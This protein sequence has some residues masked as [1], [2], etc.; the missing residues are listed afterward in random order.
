MVAFVSH[1]WYRTGIPANARSGRVQRAAAF[2]LVA[3]LP[4]LFTAQLVRSAVFRSDSRSPEARVLGSP[5]LAGIHPG[6]ETWKRQ[7]LGDFD[8]L[9]AHLA[10]MEP[11]DAPLFVM[12]NEPMLYFVSARPPLFADHAMVLFLAGWDMLPENDRATPP[13]S[14]LIGRLA[15]S[16]DAILVHRVNDPSIVNLVKTFP[17]LA[18]YIARHYRV[19]FE[20][21]DYRILR[22]AGPNDTGGS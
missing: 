11:P 20:V 10:Q 1:Q 18:R 22:K 2:L 4:V 5:H 17:Q 14:A 21:G 6:P 13:A 3:L 12:Q 16:P 8:A 15:A 7:R 9:A 19:V